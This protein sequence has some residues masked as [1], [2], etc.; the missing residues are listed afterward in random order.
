MQRLSFFAIDASN[1]TIALE[2]INNNKRFECNWFLNLD[3][4]N[5]IKLL[6]YLPNCLLRNT[7]RYTYYFSHVNVTTEK[8]VVYLTKLI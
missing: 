2:T 1:S 3:L 6:Q 7:T 4:I 8:K 5:Y